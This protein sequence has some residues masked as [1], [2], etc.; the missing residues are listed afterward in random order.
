MKNTVSH[1]NA[2]RSTPAI[3]KI[4]PFLLA[5]TWIPNT[6]AVTSTGS[7]TLRQSAGV[8]ANPVRY[9]KPGSDEPLGKKKSSS[10]KKKSRAAVPSAGSGCI[11]IQ[12]SALQVQEFLQKVV[13]D[14]RWAV[15][16]EQATEDFWNFS[17][18]ID[19]EELAAYTMPSPELRISWSAGKASLNVRTNELSDGYTRV[20]ITAKFEGY[21]KQEDAFAPKRESWPLTSNGEIEAKL[22][23]SLKDHFA[24]A[25]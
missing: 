13:R 16:N 15:A 6:P 8:P 25:H 4:L 14:L 3:R 5:L 21:G 24:A 10:P 23:T 9:C 17:I 2:L 11:E 7:A 20:L 19:A 18:P 12:Q 22:I 1:D